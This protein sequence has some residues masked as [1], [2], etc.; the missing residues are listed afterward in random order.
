MGR[1]SRKLREREFVDLTR[2]LLDSEQ[3]R[4]MGRWKHH[5]PVTTL[6]HSLFVAF[7]NPVLGVLVGA[8]VTA[9]IQS[10]SASMGSFRL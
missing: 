8:L 3:V 6:D 1:L 2:E 9:L 5:G 7:S 10:S 4:M